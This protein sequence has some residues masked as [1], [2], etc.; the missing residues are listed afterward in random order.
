MYFIRYGKYFDSWSVHFTLGSVFFLYQI[1]LMYVHEYYVGCTMYIVNA[2][3]MSVQSI[4][5]SIQENLQ[6]MMSETHDDC[7]LFYSLGNKS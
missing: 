1:L 2:V 5:S 7:C 4:K 6:V 3:L